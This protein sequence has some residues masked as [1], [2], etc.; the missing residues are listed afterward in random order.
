MT[1]YRLLKYIMVKW[2]TAFLGLALLTSCGSE[3]QKPGLFTLMEKTGIDFVNEVSDTK[4]FNIFSYRNFYN[5]GGCAIGD[6]N[7]DGL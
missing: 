5:G 3:P 6:I 4:D 7:N 1:S 2:I